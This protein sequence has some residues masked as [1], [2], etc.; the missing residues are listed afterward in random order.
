MVP[1]FAQ[2]LH[3]AGHVVVHE[4]L[5]IF[6]SRVDDKGLDSL[7]LNM[8]NLVPVDTPPGQDVQLAHAPHQWYTVQT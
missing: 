4:G 2:Q 8:Q 3:V 7:R 1:V 5:E 6:C